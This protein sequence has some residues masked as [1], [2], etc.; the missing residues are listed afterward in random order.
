[1]PLELIGRHRVPADWRAPVLHHARPLRRFYWFLL[2]DAPEPPVVVRPAPRSAPKPVAGTDLDPL[3]L[4][5]AWEKAFDSATRVDSR[6]AL[7]A[8]AP[9]YTPVV[10][11]KVAAAPRG[12]HSRLRARA[13]RR[14]RRDFSRCSTSDT[15]TAGTKTYCVPL[16]FLAGV[17]ADELLKESPD[18]VV[19]RV[20]G[21]RRGVL[22]ERLDLALP[23]SSSRRSSTTG[24]SPRA[25]AISSPPAF[26]RCPIASGRPRSTACRSPDS[27]A[28]STTRRF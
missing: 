10:L 7:P 6:A 27:A 28:T 14:R 19:A 1:M 24:S 11:G 23:A 25:P 18:L 9:G 17:P 13:A 5:P 12:A 15:P 26:R 21:A 16:A 8:A 3:L 4:G 22:H 2:R 20:S